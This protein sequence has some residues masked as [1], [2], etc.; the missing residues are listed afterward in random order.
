MSFL[1]KNAMNRK[2]VVVKP[3]DSVKKAVKLLSAKGIGCLIVTENDKPVGIL[4]E[5][6]VLNRI[7]IPS[8]STEKTKVKQIMTKKLISLDSEKNIADAAN[9]LEKNKI[10]KLPIIEKGKLA[11]IITMTD[12]MKSMRKIEEEQAK[13]LRR[14]CEELHSTKIELQ[15]K[16]NY[17]ERTS[18][19]I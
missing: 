19:E 15:T 8:L 5:R 3:E 7:V 17:L 9:L 14:V 1:I 6:D 2:V 11:G 18:K 4:T 16:I 13:K 12:L 10:K